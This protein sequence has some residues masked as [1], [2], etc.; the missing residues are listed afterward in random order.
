V[1]LKSP[2]TQAGGSKEDPLHLPAF[3]KLAEGLPYAKHVHSKLICSVTREI[4]N[5]ANPP[6][7]LPNGYVYSQKAVAVIM[8]KNDGKVV[9][10]KTGSVYGL[11]ELRRAFIV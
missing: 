8:G 11:D 3:Q 9:C 5:D 10:P 7:V 4:M 2:N 6:L 1:A